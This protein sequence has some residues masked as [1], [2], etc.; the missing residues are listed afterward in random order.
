MPVGVLQSH[1]FSIYRRLYEQQFE[2]AWTARGIF[3]P[4]VLVHA[5]QAA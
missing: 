2:S 4:H 5:D 1:H 3:E